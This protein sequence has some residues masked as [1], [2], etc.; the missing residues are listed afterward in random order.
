MKMMAM[1]MRTMMRLTMKNK[2]S[3]SEDL[4]F[5]F[6]FLVLDAKGG[7]EILSIYLSSWIVSPMCAS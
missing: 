1:M 2:R 6:S 7:E 4:A 3:P 5:P